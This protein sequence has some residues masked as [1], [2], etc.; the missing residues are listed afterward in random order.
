MKFVGPGL[1]IC[2][3]STEPENRLS[4]WPVW[5]FRAVE[6]NRGPQTLH[7]RVWRRRCPSRL[8]RRRHRS[9]SYQST[10]TGTE[11]YLYSTFIL[12]IRICFLAETSTLDRRV[13]YSPR[14]RYLNHLKR[15]WLLYSFYDLEPTG[16]Y[17][18]FQMWMM[19]I[20]LYIISFSMIKYKVWRS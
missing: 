11:T 8:K 5:E 14:L 10:W 2:P 18:R 16:H 17:F 13:P 9:S 19:F 7:E 6:T 3:D 4:Q 1:G 20:L 15:G 12:W